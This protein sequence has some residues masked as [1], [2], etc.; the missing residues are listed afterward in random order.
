MPAFRCLV[1]PLVA[2]A[3]VV[4]IASASAATTVGQTGTV[5]GSG[6][7]G[8]VPFS[9]FQVAVAAGNSYRV[10]SPGVITSWSSPA[11]NSGQT[12][13]EKLKVY[14]ATSAADPAATGNQSFFTVGESQPQT[15][16]TQPGPYPTRI[17]VQGGDFIGM[18]S[19]STMAPCSF[20]GAAA[21]KHREVAF[22]DPAPGT[23]TT[24]GMPPSATRVNVAATLEPDADQDG[25]GDET[26]DLCLSLPGSAQGCPRADLAL[27]K[28]ARQGAE[29]DLVTYTLVARNDGPDPVPDVGVRDTLPANARVVSASG[30][31]GACIASGALLDCPVGSLASGASAVITTV[32]RLRAGRQSNTAKVYSLGA[33][34]LAASRAPGAGDPNP[35]NDTAGATLNVALPAVSQT[36]VSPR[37]FRLGTLL[38]RFT[39]RP[40]VGT[41][42]SFKLSEPARTT[43]TFSQPKTGRKVGRR[44]KT[45]TRANRRK[46]RCTIPNVRG[47]LTF[48]G[49]AGTNRIRF[50]GRLS[51]S[52]K[53]KPGRYTLTIT[54]TDS[55]GN[56]STPKATSFTI[57][58]G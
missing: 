43:L 18:S 17:P 34:L 23:T 48:N 26:Q 6:C 12:G 15:P 3:G 50:Q 11:A 41:T 24:F 36:R 5:T 53:L 28:T 13:I 51:R 58:R 31:L 30:P 2:L 49:H 39:R 4:F 8:F 35:A 27:S 19:L 57:V 16:A 1:G 20:P 42:I 46:P 40:P 32:V 45:L 14:R 25:F 56:R 55:A 44:C 10:P 22:A 37:T 21:D 9:D 29:S 33:L 52:R 7:G 54:A 38:P 47:T